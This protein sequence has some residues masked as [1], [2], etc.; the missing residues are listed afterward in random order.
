M[1]D[2]FRG[3]MTKNFLSISIE[4]MSLKLLAGQRAKVSAW[5]IIPFNPRFLK[6]GFIANQQGLANVIK[7]ALSKDEFNG[8][9]RVFASLPA[10][11]STSRILEVPDLR[12]V[13]PEVVI[14]Q[15]AKR[16]MGYSAENS[17]LFWEWLNRSGGRQRFFVASVPKEP[18][19]TLIETLK[20]AGLR[21]DRIDTTVFALSRAV[22][23]R[24]AIIVALEANSIDTIII[25]DSIPVSTRSSFLGE[26]VQNIDSLPTLVTDALENIITFHNESNPANPLPPDIPIYLLG[27]GVL[28]NPNIVS[29]VE[30]TLGRS[31]AEFKPPILYPEGLPKAELA[32][33]IGLVL[34]E[35]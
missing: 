21:P 19:I 6:G 4:G 15:Q 8:R 28:L 29:A 35:L 34:K 23:E 9:R 27:S 31:V 22:N 17:L 2:M 11:H 24:Q 1:V 33:S 7:T 10:F 13:R 32:V 20:L 5:V 12:Q 14:P 26:G 25:I 3:L 30:N 18:V 16:D